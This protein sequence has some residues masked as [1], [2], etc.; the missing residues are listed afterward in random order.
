VS[1]RSYTRFELAHNQLEAAIALYINNRDR[2][3]AITL[4]GAADVLL[5]QLVLRA[6]KQ[7]FTDRAL[8]KELAT[9]RAPITREV[10]GREVNDMLFINQ[11]KHFDDDAQDVIDLDVDECA[12]AAILKA[13][14]NYVDLPEHQRDLVLAFKFW[15]NQNLDLRKYNINCDP[16]WTPLPTEA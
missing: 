12:L 10:F 6:G 7:N 8:E 13:L 15:V 5:A 14:A 9:G 11:L 2:L 4:A 16:N 3:S 1:L